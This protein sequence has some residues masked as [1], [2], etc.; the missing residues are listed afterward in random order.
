MKADDVAGYVL[1]AMVSS[2]SVGS[3]ILMGLNRGFWFGIGTG[4]IAWPILIVVAVNLFNFGA[5]K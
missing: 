5:K 1:I 3:G 2:L 4:L